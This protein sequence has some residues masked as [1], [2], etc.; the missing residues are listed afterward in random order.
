MGEKWQDLTRKKLVKTQRWFLWISKFSDVFGFVK[1]LS[2]KWHVILYLLFWEN[3]NHLVCIILIQTW[4]FS[5][6]IFGFL[7]FS[8]LLSFNEETVYDVGKKVT[9]SEM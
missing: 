8:S 9:N 5:D 6:D 1:N 3:G 7:S 4:T 2:Q